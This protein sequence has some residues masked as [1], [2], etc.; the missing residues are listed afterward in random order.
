MHNYV[1]IIIN[2]M[3]K[4]LTHCIIRGIGI[5]L[6]SLL[7]VIQLILN[8]YISQLTLLRAV[9]RYMYVYSLINA[10][11]L[12]IQ[13]EKGKFFMSVKVICIVL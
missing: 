1:I 12:N 10:G 5:I 6:F 13:I 8:Y 7:I 4:T 3:T 9:Y 2:I 11:P